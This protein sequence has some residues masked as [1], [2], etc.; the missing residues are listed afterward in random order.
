[1]PPVVE[2]LRDQQGL[3][4]TSNPSLRG[5]YL[6]A[7]EEAGR[8]AIMASMQIYYGSETLTWNQAAA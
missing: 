4:A 3:S 1:V 5:N 2:L 7:I 8:A 6:N